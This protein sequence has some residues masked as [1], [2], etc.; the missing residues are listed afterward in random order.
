MDEC[1]RRCDERF[2]GR[3]AVVVV[4]LHTRTFVCVPEASH[5]CN[6]GLLGYA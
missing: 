5:A 6:D 1:V 4:S 2:Y 3:M